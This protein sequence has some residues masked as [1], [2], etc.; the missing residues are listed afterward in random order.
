MNANNTRIITKSTSKVRTEFYSGM[1]GIGYVETIL[2]GFL[3]LLLMGLSL[4]IPHLYISIP[5]DFL[6]FFIFLFLITPNPKG[7][8]KVYNY[9]INAM[10]FGL[11]KKRYNNEEILHFF[12]F[13]NQEQ[14]YLTLN[15][16]QIIIVMEISGFDISLLTDEECNSYVMS[17]ARWFKN[18][19]CKIQLT[20]I[21]KHFNLQEQN[22]YLCNLADYW[23]KEFQDKKINNKTY[24]NIFEQL[25]EFKD[26]NFNIENDQ[27]FKRSTFYL[28]VY[29]NNQRELEQVIN[30]FNL[31][32]TKAKLVV[33]I[34]EK[35]ETISM[36]KNLF[37]PL[38][39]EKISDT[40]ELIN[41]IKN[42]TMTFHK[43]YWEFNNTF[44][45]ITTIKEYPNLVGDGWLIKLGNLEQT[46][47]LCNFTDL[48]KAQSLKM[49]DKA[50]ERVNLNQLD[51]KKVSAEKE[52]ELYL[53]NFNY[54]IDSLKEENEKLK[55][56]QIYFI[57]YADSLEKLKE[58]NN[59]LY[60]VI[61]ECDMTY[62]NL[63]FQQEIGIYNIFN[64]I[65]MKDIKT[66]SNEMAVTTI[67]AMFP[68]VDNTL[69]DSKGL[70]MGQT[71]FGI[72]YYFDIK[73]KD[74]NYRDSF[75]AFIVGK[76][77]SG[78]SY[79]VKKQL[80]WLFL[81]KTR[82]FIIDP[83][84][85]FHGFVNKYNAKVIDCGQAK[86]GL[87]NPL[88]IFNSNLQSH[89]RNLEQWFKLIFPDIS[90]HIISI[91]EELLFEVYDKKNINFGTTKEQLRN[92]KINEWPILHDLYLLVTNK[93]E[94]SKD[95]VEK[96]IKGYLKQLSSLGAYGQ[97]WNG[98]TTLDLSLDKFIILDVYT[99]RNNLKMINA[100]LFLMLQFLENEAIKNKN[101]NELLPEKD[102]EWVCIA[103]DEAHLL[104]D[105]HN[106]IALQFLYEMVKRAR[107]YNTSV[108]I[109]TQNINDFVG[110]NGVKKQSEGIMNNCLYQFVHNL[111]D[112]DLQD[113]NAILKASG[114]LNEFEL[115]AIST[116]KQGDCLFAIG[117]HNRIFLHIQASEVEA[118]AWMKDK[119]MI[120]RP[121][122]KLLN[123]YITNIEINHDEVAN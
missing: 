97:L 63:S 100:Q 105:K 57:T 70:L 55:L 103:V 29:V 16:N 92:L 31:Y 83:E 7:N 34:L 121:E 87:I 45:S 51:T 24:E 50:I 20:K 3:I 56:T 26:I 73:T 86:T 94:H 19:D 1:G 48:D 49:L 95:S 113:Y 98:Y 76:T 40:K 62:N 41:T 84:R 61:K 66:S 74:N 44:Y 67:A 93:F 120:D 77:G 108:Y 38:N 75:N 43:N 107:K 13:K 52:N 96:E 68:F 112:K 42:S 22:E 30:H 21:E 33:K 114:G 12:P 10:T 118:T 89:I 65:K 111:A 101:R 123:G 5:L 25:N 102:Q 60:G 104:I 72:P 15:N 23:E 78:K 11:R 46:N 119:N 85:E 91:L 99:L 9:L 71:S 106:L 28:T 54:L 39:N 6:C 4:S 110:D 117:S 35:E 17:L 47:L 64:N 122:N 80:N 36:I 69:M 88:Q 27:N 53:R 90:D 32:L 115:Q 116:A 18:I 58:V 79:N 82:V 109:V 14:K 8:G 37:L 59:H 2:F 81:N